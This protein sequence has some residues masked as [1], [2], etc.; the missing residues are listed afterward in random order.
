MNR[1][2]NMNKNTSGSFNSRPIFL[3]EKAPTIKIFLEEIL[4]IEAFGNHVSIKTPT[5][6]FTVN[7]TMK[8][9]EGMLPNANFIRVHRSYIV[10]L[11]K[12]KMLH[13]KSLVIDNMFIPISNL[14][15]R[16]LKKRLKEA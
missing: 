9:I 3:K 5:D 12:V 2:I 10:P 4:Y 13:E 1:I 7:E 15:K 16:D 8:D 6:R 14:Y 11:N